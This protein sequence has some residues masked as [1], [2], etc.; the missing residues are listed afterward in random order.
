MRRAW[1]HVESDST[2]EGLDL[3]PAEQN[4][5]TLELRGRRAVAA[6]GTC[7]SVWGFG[8]ETDS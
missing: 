2:S 4:G 8:P 7:F 6:T 5:A 3:R 1:S